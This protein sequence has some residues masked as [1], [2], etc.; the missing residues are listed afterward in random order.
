MAV[1]TLETDNSSSKCVKIDGKKME[2]VIQ[3]LDHSI[4]KLRRIICLTR[5]IQRPERVSDGLV[6]SSVNAVIITLIVF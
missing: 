3:N 5:I 2:K 4:F 1:F 6:V